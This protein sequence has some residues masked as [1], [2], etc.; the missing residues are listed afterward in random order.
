MRTVLGTLGC[1]AGVLLGLVMTATAQGQTRRADVHRMEINNGATQKVR[2][3]SRGTSPGENAALRDLERSENELAYVRSLQDLRREYVSNERQVEA[4]RFQA[5][6]DLYGRYMA[7]GGLGLLGTPAALDSNLYA[8]YNLGYYPG[9]GNFGLG[10]Y[11]GLGGGNFG[12]GFGRGYGG[13]LGAGLL[14]SSVASTIGTDDPIK[15][16]MASVIA[17]QAT[18]QF[19]AMVERNMDRAVAMVAGSP[20]IRV[21]LG[22]PSRSGIGTAGAKMDAVEPVELT[23]KDG[24]VVRGSKMSEDKDWVTVT[25][26][27]GRKIRVRMADVMRIEEGK[28]AVGGAAGD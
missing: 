2:Y 28:P 8:A 9:V 16:S 21:A 26:S 25:T 18:P 17:Q 11:F 13:L 22:M 12:L 15:D 1:G 14:S 4:I 20:S 19:A 7:T 3:Y 5:Q 23:L 10:G 27:S 6:Q 24:T